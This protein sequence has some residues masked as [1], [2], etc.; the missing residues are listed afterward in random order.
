MARGTKQNNIDQPVVNLRAWSAS[1]DY[2]T[3]AQPGTTRKLHILIERQSMGFPLFHPLDRREPVAHSAKGQRG[4]CDGGSSRS[5]E[6]NT[7]VESPV[8][9]VAEDYDAE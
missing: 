6:W 8:M 7:P 4:P 5:V 1:P 3:D 2:A 9:T